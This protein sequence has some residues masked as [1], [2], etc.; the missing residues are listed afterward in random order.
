[1]NHPYLIIPFQPWHEPY[2]AQLLAQGKGV[3]LVLLPEV[4]QEE[5]WSNSVLP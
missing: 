2:V 5:C 4:D 1:M 3:R